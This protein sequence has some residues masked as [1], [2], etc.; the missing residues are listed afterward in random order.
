M[1]LLPLPQL[2]ASTLMGGTSAERADLAHLLATQLATLLVSRNPQEQ[3]RVVLG[4]GLRNATVSA[5]C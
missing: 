2:S 1:P 5:L 4:L 3:R